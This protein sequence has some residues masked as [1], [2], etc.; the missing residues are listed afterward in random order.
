MDVFGQFKEKIY[1]KVFGGS[2]GEFSYAQQVVALYMA[3]FTLRLYEVD[4][5]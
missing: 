3:R 2:S 4:N 1:G 5:E